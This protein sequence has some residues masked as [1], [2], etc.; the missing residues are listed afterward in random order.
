MPVMGP[1]YSNKDANDAHKAVMDILREKY[2]IHDDSP[3][4]TF[5]LIDFVEL[6]QEDSEALRTAIHNLFA[7]KS[8]ED[9]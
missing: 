7:H 8:W 5:G 3:P 4:P 1:S 2:R 6:R 9:W